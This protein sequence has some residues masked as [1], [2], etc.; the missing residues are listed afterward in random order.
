MD[1]ISP[2]SLQNNNKFC[3]Q[4]HTSAV[5]VSLQKSLNLLIDLSCGRTGFNIQYGCVKSLSLQKKE[6]KRQLYNALFSR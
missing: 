6:L 4:Q 3:Y 1:C 2:G 5:E